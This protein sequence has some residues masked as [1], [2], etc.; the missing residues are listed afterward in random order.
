MICVWQ[1]TFL[2]RTYYASQQTIIKPF[3]TNPTNQNNFSAFINMQ[4][5]KIYQINN[6][7]FAK[8]D[9]NFSKGKTYFINKFYNKLQVNLVKIESICN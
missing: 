5:K 4:K 3:C 2:I 7:P 8:V 9:K 1:I 6:K